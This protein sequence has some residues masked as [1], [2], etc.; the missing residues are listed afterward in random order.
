MNHPPLPSVFVLFVR[1]Y[2][3]EDRF[4]RWTTGPSE[5][6]FLVP[7]LNIH[8]VDAQIALLHSSN[9]FCAHYMAYVLHRSTAC[10]LYGIFYMILNEYLT[11]ILICYQFFYFLENQ[12]LTKQKYV[13]IGKL[14][15]LK[16]CFMWFSTLI[17]WRLATL[18]TPAK[19]SY[20]VYIPA[21]L[22]SSEYLGEIVHQVVYLSHLTLILLSNSY[23]FRAQF[24]IKAEESLKV[25]KNL[26]IKTDYI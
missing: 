9:N 1:R 5:I 18:N 17:E 24:I 21:V 12:M 7:S 20:N 19:I 15:I 23:P 26:T 4:L 10:L 8:I 11:L 22:V 6:W 25:I 16:F 14:Q 2:T 13:V 3:I